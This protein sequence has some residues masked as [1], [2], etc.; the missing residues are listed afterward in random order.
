MTCRPNPPARLLIVPGLFDSGPAHW[1][2]WLQAGHP[3]ALR[4]TQHHWAVPDLD[5]WA[6]RIQNMLERASPGPWIAVAHSFGVL[7]LAAHL[8]RHPESP[9]AAAL[10]VAP[11]DP[12]RFGLAQALPQR[13]LGRPT[14]LVASSNDPWLKL[15]EAERWAKR[16]CCPLVNLGQ[17]GHINA[18]SGFGPWPLARQWVTAAGQRMARQQPVA[19]AASSEFAYRAAN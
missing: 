3:Q 16:W 6:G 1:Q 7:A 9:I 5:R 4:V 13:S 15:G 12:A 2:T 17:A 10:L 11:A 8:Q 18:E 14:T 19:Q